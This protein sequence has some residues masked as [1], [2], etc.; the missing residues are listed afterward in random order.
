MNSN[1]IQLRVELVTQ[2]GH[3]ITK[4]AT[5]SLNADEDDNFWLTLKHAL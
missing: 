3:N 5:V 1:L 2:V 4:E